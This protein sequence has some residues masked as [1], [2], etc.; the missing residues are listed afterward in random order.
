[1]RIAPGNGRKAA[2]VADH[3]RD[4]GKPPRGAP[5]ESRRSQTVSDV[6]Q[7]MLPSSPRTA[8]SRLVAGLAALL[9]SMGSLA[10]TPELPPDLAGYRGQVVVVDFWASWCK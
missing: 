7:A 10:A 9:A 3:W 6:S 5:G 2:V 4:S 1:M 8:A